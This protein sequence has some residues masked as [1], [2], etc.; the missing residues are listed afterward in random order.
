MAVAGGGGLGDA[1]DAGDVR[2]EGRDRDVARTFAHDLDQRLGDIGFG[3]GSAGRKD[4]SGIADRQS[5]VE[6][7][8]V[9]VRVDLGGRRIIKKKT[10]K[11]QTLRHENKKTEN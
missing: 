5:V 11:N 10:R 6:G 4:V 8:S 3:T 1:F 2:G 9:S 7:K